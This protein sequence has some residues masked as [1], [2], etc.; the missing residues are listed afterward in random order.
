MDTV[1]KNSRN[2]KK[3]TSDDQYVFFQSHLKRYLMDKV[4]FYVVCAMLFSY[5]YNLPVIKYSVTGDNEFRLYDVLGLFVFYYAYK[6][7]YLINTVIKKVPIF[8]Y[9][10]LLL[11][12]I[13]FGL[14]LTLFFSIINGK[15]TFFFQVFLYYYHF[16]VFYL[17][18]VFLYIFC[19]NHT[20]RKYFIGCVFIFSIISNVIVVLQYM[21][22]IPF[23][24]SKTYWDNY[25]FYSG[26]LGPNK[27]VL[28]M[29][30]LFVLVLGI[31]VA[32]QRELKVNKV[33]LIVAL[34]LNLYTAIL[35]GSR[36]TYVALGVF[37]AYFAIRSTL[38]F[39]FLGSLLACVFFLLISFNSDLYDKLD[40]TLNNR[41]VA[42]I[43]NV[44][45]EKKGE[46][47]ELYEKLGSGRDQLTRG[48]IFYLI[49][50]PQVIPFGMGFVNRFNTAPG[51]SAHNMYLQVI[52]ELGLVGF[53]IYFG[54]LIQ[55]L[56]LDF[57]QNKGFSI[58]LKGLV[59]AML[60]ALYFGEH[61]YIYRPLFGIL[62]LFLA[63]TSIF[64][65]I[66]H[67]VNID[68]K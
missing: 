59:L 30:S 34:V 25:A 27:I 46:I 66:L 49:E 38:K 21:N 32:L 33:L 22:I 41:V 9:L 57:K 68:T 51:L 26:T 54:W 50:N 5:F 48:N 19:V 28:G 65:S 4:L 20:I 12:W 43:N 6:Y 58:A 63:I 10:K 31:G 3:K 36:T 40:E 17:S 8:N 11:I 45:E 52:K 56:V 2:R 64:V 13:V 44:Q 7:F 60:V 39:V 16:W 35:S 42:K 61:L 24:W 53:F 37:L 1:I 18:S 62:G 15:V 14:F 55:Y 29:T 67:R 23:L 47:G